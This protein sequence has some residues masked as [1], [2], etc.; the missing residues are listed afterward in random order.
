VI[1]ERLAVIDL[2]TTGANPVRDRVT[3]IGIVE[4]EGDRVTT[5]G[6]L[7]NPEQPIPEFIQQLTGIRNK[8]VANAPTYEVIT[9]HDPGPSLENAIADTYANQFADNL[10]M[11]EMFIRTLLEQGTSSILLACELGMP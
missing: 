9:L 10:L 3:E 1:P 11:P 2:E 8:M 6:T 5:W 7:V 4:A